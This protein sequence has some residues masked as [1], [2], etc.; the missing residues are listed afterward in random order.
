MCAE[1]HEHTHTGIDRGWVTT[2]PCC[3]SEVSASSPTIHSRKAVQRDCECI[4]SMREGGE[5]HDCKCECLE[6]SEHATLL[7]MS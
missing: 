6:E 3:K 7:K 5:G 1:T 4:S 2:M